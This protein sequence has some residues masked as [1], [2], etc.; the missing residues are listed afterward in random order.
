[1]PAAISLA[2][3]LGAG[4]ASATG[5]EQIA[6]DVLVRVTADAIVGL[7]PVT[8]QVRWEHGVS[9]SIESVVRVGGAQELLLSV[10]DA[11][12]A[13]SL[14]RFDMC[15]HEVEWTLPLFTGAGPTVIDS[16]GLST[17]E[18][19]A[20]DA[21][22]YAY[23][24]RSEQA[25]VVGLAQLDLGSRRPT[26]FAGPWY[27]VAGGV[28]ALVGAPSPTLAVVGARSDSSAATT[29]VYTLDGATLE[30]RDSVTA[31]TFGRSGDVW[32]ATSIDEGGSLIV[33][34]GGWLGT[35]DVGAGTVAGQIP[36]S[37]TGR[38]HPS[39]DGDLL[40]LTD[41]GTGFDLP[42]SG[43]V[44]VLGEALDARGTIDVSSPVGGAPGTATST[45]TRSAAFSPDGA[46]AY[47]LGGTRERGPVYP[48]QPTRVFVIDVASRQVT[49][50]LHLGGFELGELFWATC[51]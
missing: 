9:G 13:R 36:V 51:A 32:S 22:G 25:G 18:V 38:L 41:V 11:G 4:C 28:V 1:M 10:R 29:S 44:H 23:L 40:L 26:A 16:I 24:W 47:V 2:I 17:A 21:G 7:D 5:P 14:R 42:G 33:G 49:D 37:A 6:G 50:V 8:G 31:E 45:V 20:A 12:F 43:L 27:V 48:V 46:I 34:G 30:V 39:P 15:R 19:L 35:F 3:C